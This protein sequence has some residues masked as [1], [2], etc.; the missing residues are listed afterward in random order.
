MPKRVVPE[1][2]GKRV[3]VMSRTTVEMRAKLEEAASQSGRSL[4]QEVEARLEKS[5]A[6]DELY[7]VLFGDKAHSQNLARL[8]SKTL[9]IIE[10]ITGKRWVED[11]ET[12]RQCQIAYK[13]I[14]CLMFGPD[15]KPD[16]S[17]HYL[18]HVEPGVKLGSELGVDI[19]EAVMRDLGLLMPGW[20]PDTISTFPIRKSVEITVPAKTSGKTK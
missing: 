14:G 4:G 1:G 16:K 2:P 15:R 3:P 12:A 6:Q 17:E 7:K 18:S 8:T 19:A 13:H 20:K 10:S 5:F 11:Y 9:Q